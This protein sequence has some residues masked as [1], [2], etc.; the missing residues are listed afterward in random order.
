MYEVE[1][2][3]EHKQALSANVIVENMFASFDEEGHRHLLLDSIID[4]RR[5]DMAIKK[6]DAFITS[7]N[8]VK[9]QRET[10]KGWEILVQWK[11]GSTTWSK[12]KDMKDSYPVQLTEY[13]VQNKI[14]DEPAFAWWVP[15]T[16]KKKAIIIKKVKSK[17]WL[18]TH[19][20]GIRIPKTVKEAIEIDVKNGNTL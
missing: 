11:D 18:R 19:K 1:F 9:R 2:L 13:A 16:I 12:L 10:T 17:Y 14:D 8:G 4:A 15:Y 5:T 20:Y 7:S 6:E 3:N